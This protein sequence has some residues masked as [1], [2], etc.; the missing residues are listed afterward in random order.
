MFFLTFGAMLSF[1]MWSKLVAKKRTNTTRGYCCRSSSFEGPQN[2]KIIVVFWYISK[3][4]MYF[5]QKHFWMNQL[6]T[7]VQV[8]GYHR[9]GPKDETGRSRSRSSRVRLPR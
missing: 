7:K 2:T 6:W 1:V 8:S 3:Y 4:Y 9:R 5:Y